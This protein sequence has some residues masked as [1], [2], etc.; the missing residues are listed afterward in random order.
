MII[1]QRE[2]FFSN[3]IR[4]RNENS[5]KNSSRVAQEPRPRGGGGPLI[6]GGGPLIPGGGPLIPG[7][8]PPAPIPGGGPLIPGGGPL[9]PGGGPRAGPLPGGGPRAA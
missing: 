9:E 4:E 5:K 1:C 2:L 6:P 8:G 7:G 3:K